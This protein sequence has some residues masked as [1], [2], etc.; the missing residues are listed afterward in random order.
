MRAIYAKRSRYD[1]ETPEL[2]ESDFV[3]SAPTGP[4]IEDANDFGHMDDSIS[5]SMD[6]NYEIAAYD[7]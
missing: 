4:R 6:A 7:A 3:F 5:F 2:D 1:I